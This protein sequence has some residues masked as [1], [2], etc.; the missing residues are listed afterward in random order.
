MIDFDDFNNFDD[1]LNKFSSIHD[2]PISEEKLGAYLDGS[3]DNATM[4]ELDPIIDGDSDLLS[5]VTDIEQDTFNHGTTVFLGNDFDSNPLVG[6]V[7]NS[8]S[9]PGREVDDLPD[10]STIELPTI[11]PIDPTE[12]FSATGT[13]DFDNS[14]SLN[15]NDP[16][17]D[18]TIFNNFDL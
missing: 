5:I 1:L 15:T 17:G 11:E 13:I 18:N 8:V 7:L 16:T 2:L 9:L 12:N 3:L 4:L 14:A 10:L 6:S